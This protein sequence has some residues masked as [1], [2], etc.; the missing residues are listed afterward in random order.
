MGT[1]NKGILGPFS[2]KVGTV[3][4]AIWRGKFVLRSL[5]AISNRLPTE[6]QALQRQKFTTVS[7]FLTPFYPI[8]RKFYGSNTG[9]LTRVNNAMS[10][11]MKEAV[12][13]N[14]PEFEME[15][16]KVMLTKGDLLGLNSVVLAAVAGEIIKV[17]WVDNSG[18][19]QA[20]DTDNVIVA[21]YEPSNQLSFYSMAVATRVDGTFVFTLPPNLA[22]LK[23]EVWV[24]VVS[25]NEKLYATSTYAGSVN[26]I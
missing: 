1:Y 15:Y 6:G 9:V 22:G 25:T 8:I 26:L 24:S 21:V 5:P 18:Q 3:V 14:S 20:K 10:F 7:D 17:T 12:V 13:F 11:H 16:N 4:G 2:G 19:G 23:V